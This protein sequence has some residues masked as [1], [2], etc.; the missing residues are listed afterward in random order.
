LE[1]RVPWNHVF[2]AAAVAVLFLL[3]RLKGS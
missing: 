2:L 1:G 3:R